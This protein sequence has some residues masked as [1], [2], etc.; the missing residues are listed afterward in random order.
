MISR[1]TFALSFGVA[2][3]AMATGSLNDHP[4]MALLA[5][6]RPDVRWDP[7]TI[8]AADFD[9]DGKGDF[10]VVGY[11]GSGLILAIRTSHGTRSQDFQYL[12]FGIGG[13]Q[14]DAICAAPAKLI[15]VP[16]ICDAEGSA[17]PGCHESRGASGLS[18]SDHNGDCDPINL[19]WDHDHQHMTWWRN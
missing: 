4:E 14:Q 6:A 3:V 12:S 18:L 15:A 7:N 1:V 16:L 2:A 11:V 17:L 10:A 5:K 19:Y 13:A 8:V 9:A